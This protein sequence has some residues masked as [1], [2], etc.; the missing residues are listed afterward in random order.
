MRKIKDKL[1]ENDFGAYLYELRCQNEY[2][3]EELVQKMNMV[4][5]KI[6][7][8]RKWEHDLEFP[9]LEQMYKISEIYEIPIEELMQVR[10][11]TLEEGL[12][13]IHKTIIRFLGYILGISIYG[14]VIMSYVFILVAGIWAML[15]WAEIPKAILK[16]V[17]AS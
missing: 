4:T 14:T 1:L 11:N 7:N 2:T 6:K 13:G 12:K 15:L 10:T 16:A 9:N 5:V 17:G 3:I 8:V